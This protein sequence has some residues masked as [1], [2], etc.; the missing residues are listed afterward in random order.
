M[1]EQR[2]FEAALKEIARAGPFS[3]Q[4]DVEPMRGSVNTFRLAIGAFRCLF[5]VQHGTLRVLRFGFRPG[6]YP[7]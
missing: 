5:Q 6:L 7:W 3:S 4:Q 1:T 2:L